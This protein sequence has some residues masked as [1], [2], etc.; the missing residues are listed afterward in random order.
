M[1][2]NKYLVIL[3][4]FLIAIG[5]VFADTITTPVRFL[6]PTSLAFTLSV[7]GNNST[8][9]SSGS[10]TTTLQFNATVTTGNKINASN[11]GGDTQTSTSPIFN[12]TNTGNVYLNM[13]INFTAALPSG[14]TVKA[15]WAD[16]AWETSCTGTAN[17]GFNFTNGTTRCAN[18]TLATNAT[19]ANM[20]VNGVGSY[21]NV[22]LWAD[23]SSVAI[24]TD[25]TVNLVHTSKAG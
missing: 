14:V 20:S 6:L 9:Y 23:Y 12:Y 22:W 17:N 11:L 18:V 1:V 2:K 24:G 8:S 7:P 4:F 25:T 13:T 16:G 10:T 15:G 21:R 19:V 3:L 5:V